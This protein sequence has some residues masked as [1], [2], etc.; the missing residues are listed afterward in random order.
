METFN[1]FMVVFKQANKGHLINNFNMYCMSLP[2][3]FSPETN[4]WFAYTL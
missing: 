4:Y 3:E 2:L 1:D